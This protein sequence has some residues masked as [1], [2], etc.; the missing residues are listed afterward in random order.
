MVQAG[1]EME[2]PDLPQAVKLLKE[3]NTNIQQVSQLVDNMLVRVKTGELTTDKG[4]SFLEMK[5][6]MLLSYLINLTYIVLR[7]CSGEKIESDPSI[8]RLIEIRTILEKI[9]PIDS[10]LKYQIDKLVKTA[11]VGVVSEDDPQSYRANPANLVSKIN[12]SDDESSEDSRDEENIKDK[13]KSS[14]IYVPP[15]LAAVH[16]DDSSSRIENEKKSKERAKKQFLNSNV[17]RELREE[18]SEAPLEVSSGNN[19][20]QSI[21]KYEQEKTEYEENYLTRLPVT[22]AEKN[23]RRKLTT[24]GMLADEVTGHTG[25]RKRKI[26]SKKGKGFKRRRTH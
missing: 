1:E 22:K 8:D 16:Y 20:K 17:M 7:K 13:G 2:Q 10:K 26:K 6:Q 19:F 4:L 9:R 5:Y 23:Q 15:K 14:N 3:M 12:S 24:V 21:S 18:Y 25:N 11:V